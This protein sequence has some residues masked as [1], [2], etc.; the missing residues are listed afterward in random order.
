MNKFLP[1]ILISILNLTIIGCGNSKAEKNKLEW[2][3][4]LLRSENTSKVT[5]NVTLLDSNGHPMSVGN[6]STRELGDLSDS[7][8]AAPDSFVWTTH[9]FSD[10]KIRLFV[11]NTYSYNRQGL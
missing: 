11:Y 1:A 3:F 4:L 6:A 10:N 2:L 5:T 9:Y 8:Q 7:L